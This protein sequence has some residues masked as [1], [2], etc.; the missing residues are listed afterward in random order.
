MSEE[1]QI[2]DYLRRAA[3]INLAFLENSKNIEKEYPDIKLFVEA[4]AQEFLSTLYFFQSDEPVTKF[5]FENITNGLKSI[6]YFT[7]GLIDEGEVLDGLEIEAIEEER[8]LILVLEN[9]SL[10]PVSK[11]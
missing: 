6:H 8:S 3:N 2:L 10:F 1:H 9:W 7:Q 5:Q 11:S 4:N